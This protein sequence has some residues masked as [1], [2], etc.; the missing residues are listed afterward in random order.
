MTETARAAAPTAIEAAAI[1]SAGEGDIDHIAAL[2]AA[3][4]DEAWGRDA[5]ARVL[6]GDHGFGLVARPARGDLG[7]EGGPAGFALYR[8]VA[9]E[10][11]LLA[12]GVAGSHRR[13]G[14][15]RGLLDAALAGAAG[16]GARAMFLEVA[17]DNGAALALY[18]SAGF[19]RI[20]RRKG[21]YSRVDGAGRREPVAALVLRRDL[22]PGLIPRSSDKG[23]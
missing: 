10:C 5:I 18:R 14:I 13:R 16:R 12:L 6:A 19:S 4:L 3:C 11:E 23:P 22:A 8:A 15:G 1:E 20:G 17:E 9:G 21:Y 2:Y 7:G